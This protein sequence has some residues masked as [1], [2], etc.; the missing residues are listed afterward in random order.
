[1]VPKSAYPPTHPHPAL[2]HALPPSAAQIA[3]AAYLAKSQTNPHLHPDALLSTSGIT[4]SAQS[5]PT[6]GLALHHLKRIVAGLRGENLIA[7]SAD[8]LAQFGGAEADTLP[9]GDDARVDGVIDGHAINTP[10]KGVLKRRR[11]TEDEVAQW[12]AAAQSSEAA[13]FGFGEV[14]AA[15]DDWQDQ[16]AYEHAQRPLTGDVGERTAAHVVRQNGAPP[17][18]THVEDEE[19]YGGGEGGAAL[20]EADKAARRAAKKAKRKGLKFEAIEQKLGRSAAG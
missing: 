6:G 9:A 1:M 4:Y 2:T 20:T 5:G 14:D 8:E 16:E 10:R 17:A 18:I 11:D 13:G 19:R 7:E 15:Q 12:A 3:L